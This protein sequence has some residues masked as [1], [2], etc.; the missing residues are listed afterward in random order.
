[1]FVLG[2]ES[3]CDET[4]CAIVE[5]GKTVLSNVIATQTEIHTPF[6][7][8]FPE[9]ACRR[10]VDVI[11][12]TVQK[13]LHQ[14]SVTPQ[15]IDLIAVATGPGLIGS[16]LIGVQVAKALSLAWG[17]PFVSVNH[18][19]AHLYAALMPL[20]EPLFPALGVVISGGHTLLLKTQ[21][22]GRYE[23]IGMTRDDAIGE[24]F[25]KVATLLSLPYPG[26]P[27]LETL[28]LQGNPTRFPF[29]PGQVKGHPW[30]FSFSGLKTSV[31]YAVKGARASKHAPL[32]ISEEEK[33]DVAASFQETALSDV[34]HK[35]LQAAEAFDCR[36]L[37]CGGGV[38]QNKRL[39]ALFAENNGRNLPIFFPPPGLVTDNG[40]MIAGLGYH[41]FCTRGGDALDAEPYSTRFK[42]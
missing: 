7:G 33:A 4:A 36:A 2:I 42:G 30:D 5:E 21:E 19:E 8:V 37:F 18:V 20:S 14:A 13:A 34:V 16:L 41:L 23:T 29:R 10:H 6:G 1:M 31:L 24:A 39:K 35:A 9:L 12:P 28:A 27:A 11:I 38:C 26:G 22:I 3:S 15:E 32:L 17:K 40:A 25:D